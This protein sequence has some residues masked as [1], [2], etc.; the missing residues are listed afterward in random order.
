MAPNE[1]ECTQVLAGEG[2]KE[3]KKCNEGYSEHL[4]GN[5]GSEIHIQ[6]SVIKEVPKDNTQDN[7]KREEDKESLWMI[8]E[9]VKI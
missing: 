8:Y 1:L 6:R 2:I 9:F 5:Q 7:G 3:I 4:M